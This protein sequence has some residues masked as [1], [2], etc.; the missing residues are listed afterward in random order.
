MNS[1]R[2]QN[3]QIQ[4]TETSSISRFNEIKSLKTLEASEK[5]RSDLAIEKWPAIWQ[6]SKSRRT[7]TVKSFERKIRLQDGSFRTAKVEIGFTQLGNLTTEDQKTYYGLIKQWEASGHSPGYTFLSTRRLAR[8]LKKKWGRNV[9][10]ATTESLRRL[11]T[12]PFTWTNAYRDSGTGEEL[13]VLD[14]F[15]ILSDLKIVRRKMDGHVT[16]EAGYFRLHDSILKNLLANYT[17][18][19]FL[20]LIL[21]FKSEIAQLLYSHVDLILARH[22]HYERRTKELFDDL[23]LQ[24]PG[25][26]KR[27]DRKRTLERALVE[28]R[29]APLSTGILNA[30]TIEE[31]KDGKDYKVVFRKI[32]RGQMPDLGTPKGISREEGIAK[33][34][35]PRESP[36][37]AQAIELVVHFYKTFHQVDKHRPNSREIAQAMSLIASHGFERAKFVVDF[38]CTA[39]PRTNYSPQTFG[40]ILQ[41][42]SR[43]LAEFDRCERARE[44]GRQQLAAQER[45]EQGEHEEEARIDE[46]LRTLSEGEYQQLRETVKRD[47]AAKFPLVMANRGSLVES[48]IRLRM[49]RMLDSGDA[50]EKRPMGSAHPI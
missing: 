13:E 46:R 35:L 37:T 3:E 41:Y 4:L 8:I 28:L 30:A 39:A 27:S 6:P 32:K 21:D 15:T 16:R 22:D 34:S 36:L 2:R 1:P 17:K 7:P 24:G 18:P 23:N 31:T 42:A 49:V 11:R 29:G 5:I 48:A 50:P 20:D 14:T 9:I 25:Y 33:T 26:R 10:D 12:T 43:A 19:V 44:L 38:S 45:R 47:F 40:G